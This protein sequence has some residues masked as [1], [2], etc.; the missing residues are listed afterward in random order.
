MLYIAF[1][2]YEPFCIVY[3]NYPNKQFIQLNSIYHYI[4]KMKHNPYVFLLVLENLNKK[5]ISVTWKFKN[6]AL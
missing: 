4:V 3:K 6:F 1:I 5:A 2:L